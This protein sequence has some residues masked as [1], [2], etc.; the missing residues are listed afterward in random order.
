MREEAAVFELSDEAI[1]RI[2]FA[3]EDQENATVVDLETG[4]ILP[5]EGRAGDRYER[6]PAWSS[7]EGYR[8]M[9]EFLSTVRQP[10]A[11][12]ELSAA[13]GKGR[14]VF[15]AFKAA[16]AAFPEVERAFRDFKIRAMRRSIS[17]WLDDLRESRGLE[18]LGPEPEDTGDLISSDFDIRI[19]RPMEVEAV[20][21]RLMKEAAAESLEYIPS[22]VADFELARLAE[23]RA[24]GGDGYCAV[25]DDEEGGALGI[26]LA[27][28]QLIGERSM[29]QV[30]FVYVREGFRRMGLGSALLAALRGSFLSEGTGLILI[31]SLFL[32]R[33]FGEELSTTG[34]RGIGVR[35]LDWVD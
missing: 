12:R 14:G 8:L 9:E 30:A 26:A 21:D 31:D 24:R 4:E 6:P 16:L 15:K 13:L 29:G 23:I 34:Y 2:V 18:R 22:L 10:S 19:L 1:E 28:R 11:R 20:L 3:M 33:E 17:S 25:A 7:R 35:V 27:Y 32:P 5:A